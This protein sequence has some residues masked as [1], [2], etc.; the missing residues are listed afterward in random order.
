[1]DAFPT[2]FTRAG[3][4]QNSF[5]RGLVNPVTYFGWPNRGCQVDRQAGAMVFLRHAESKLS[6]PAQFVA[7]QNERCIGIDDI[8]FRTHPVLAGGQFLELILW[9]DDAIF[10]EPAQRA[11]AAVWD[12]KMDRRI[13][14]SSIDACLTARSDHPRQYCGSVH[15]LILLHQPI[16]S[17]EGRRVKC[18]GRFGL[19]RPVAYATRF[20]FDSCRAFCSTLLS[21]SERRQND[22]AERRVTERK[23][24]NRTERLF[25]R[26]KDLGQHIF[27]SLFANQ[28][29]ESGA[30][31]V[32]DLQRLE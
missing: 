31:V 27:A 29:H 4:I 23:K 11:P 32:V 7:E 9:W 3:D 19:V 2:A 28:R 8:P 15:A 20:G 25:E 5:G 13:E 17:S 26:L 12:A 18:N 14:R 16:P 30:A 6:S 24:G 22:S 21:R 10:S 1:M